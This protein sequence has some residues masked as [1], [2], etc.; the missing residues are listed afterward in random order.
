MHFL[1]KY[2]ERFRKKTSYGRNSLFL[3]FLTLKSFY[4]F[5]A[6]E[7]KGGQSPLPPKGKRVKVSVH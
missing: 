4:D 6:F 2:L 7:I 1:R 3:E 5:F